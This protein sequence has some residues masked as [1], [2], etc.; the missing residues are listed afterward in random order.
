[1]KLHLTKNVDITDQIDGV[2]TVFDLPDEYESGSVILFWN[3][4]RLR[5]DVEFEETLPN[6]VTWLAQ[7]KFPSPQVGDT[8]QVQYEFESGLLAV[9]SG[10]EPD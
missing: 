2:V 3:G 7:P 6:Q 4:V 8:L 10:V 5:K 1:M 9:A